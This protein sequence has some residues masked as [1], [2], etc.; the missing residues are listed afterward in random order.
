MSEKVKVQLELSPEA[1][2]ELEDEPRRR[3]IEMLLDRMLRRDR[4]EAADSL[5]R[6]LG[7]TQAAAREAGVT[8]EDIDAELA[9]YNA[10]RRG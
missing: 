6:L 3:A 10:E 4:R 7:E 9:A 2:R 5:I 8:E 1:A